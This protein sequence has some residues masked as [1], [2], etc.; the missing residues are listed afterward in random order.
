MDMVRDIC[1][2]GLKIRDENRLKLRQPLSK[3][4][5]PI[6]DINLLDIVKGIKC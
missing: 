1:S 2:L 6:S 3:A 5:V 4:Y